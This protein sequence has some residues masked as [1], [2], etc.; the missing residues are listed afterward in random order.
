[1]RTAAALDPYERLLSSVFL[2]IVIPVRLQEDL[3]AVVIC[4]YL[5]I[6][7]GACFPVLTGEFVYL[8]LGSIHIVC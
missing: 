5:R 8:L 7:D 4:I 3:A 1:M 2:I 6:E